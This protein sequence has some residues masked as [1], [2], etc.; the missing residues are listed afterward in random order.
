[1]E[2]SVLFRNIVIYYKCYS[3]K[4]RNL[5]LGDWSGEGTPGNISNPEV[6]VA[7][8]DGTWGVAPWESRSLPR[9]FSFNHCRFISGI[10]IYVF[11]EGIPFPSVGDRSMP[12]RLFI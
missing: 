11:G 12:L 4:L 9:D 2:N 6:K 10:L 7:S 5:S 8:A 3:D 1:M